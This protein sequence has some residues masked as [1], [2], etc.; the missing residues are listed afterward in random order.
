VNA[1]GAP[2]HSRPLWIASLVTPVA[3]LT[4]WFA[5]QLGLEFARSGSV[6]GVMMR[7]LVLLILF[8]GPV[9]FGAMF[10]LG[11]PSLLLLRSQNMLTGL[12]VCLAA[13]IVTTIAIVGFMLSMRQRPGLELV[14]WALGL[15]VFAG[16]TFCLAAGIPFRRRAP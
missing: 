16:A 14:A 10:F 13:T 6:P 3:A 15:G 7:L 12:N 9:A 11:L 5:L 8:G 1:Q 4:A 2:Q